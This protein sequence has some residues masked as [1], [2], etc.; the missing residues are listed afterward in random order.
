MWTNSN[1][2]KGAGCGK[3]GGFDLGRQ[4]TLSEQQIADSIAHL[5]QLDQ[6][7]VIDPLSNF[8]EGKRAVY[9][10]SSLDDR[11]VRPVNQQA[12]Y[13]TF[14]EVGMGELS[15]PDEFIQ[16]SIK[17][18]GHG[19]K[20]TYAEEYLTFLWGALGYGQLQPRG[21]W[22]AEPAPGTLLTFDQKEFFPETL[23]WQTNENLMGRENGYVYVP[24]QCQG[25]GSQNCRLHFVLH[26][27]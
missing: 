5:K 2:W 9:I 26:G 3:S 12:Q 13:R 19:F 4:R 22:K 10:I 24:N 18:D 21:D 20:A 1:V 17:E 15:D 6:Q 16:M 23:D 11:S 14:L 8:K 27:C 7:G 25:Q